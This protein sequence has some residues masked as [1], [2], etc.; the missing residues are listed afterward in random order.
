MIEAGFCHG[1]GVLRESDA[2]IKHCTKY[3]SCHSYGDSPTEVWRRRGRSRLVS[4]LFKWSTMHITINQSTIK[5]ATVVDLGVLFDGELSVRQQVSWL[6]QTCFY[7]LRRLRSVSQKLSRDVTAKLASAFVLSRL[8]CCNAVL[9]GLPASTLAPL[10]SPRR[11]FRKRR[12]SKL[13]YQSQ[14]H[15]TRG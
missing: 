15:T 7:H 4:W 3:S 14:A 11:S 12:L 10:Q 13:F 6:S 5:P 2:R 1:F 8:D 9:T